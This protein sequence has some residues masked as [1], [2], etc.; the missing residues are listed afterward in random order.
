MS[1]S[2]VV[3]VPVDKQV[4]VA[5]YRLPVTPSDMKEA[6]VYVVN[7]A[8]TASNKWDRGVIF[9]T[10][11]AIEGAIAPLETIPGQYA[12][13][14]IKPGRY[15]LRAQRLCHPDGPGGS[16]NERF[17]VAGTI[18]PAW[19]TG[20]STYTRSYGPGLRS[21]EEVFE[22]LGGKTYVFSI[23]PNCALVIKAGGVLL[24]PRIREVD[25]PGGKYLIMSSTPAKKP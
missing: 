21:G 1:V 25:E 10:A 18:M 3:Q 24:Y 5:S 13:A 15:A 7:K 4:A 16:D 6:V 19:Q 11:F 14:K 23:N 22:F 17:P 9:T 2:E 12:V 8:E 20:W